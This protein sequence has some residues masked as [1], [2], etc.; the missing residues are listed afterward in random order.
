MDERP[1]NL[2]AMLAEAKDTSELM[3]DLAYAALF[4]ADD[5]MAEE[6]VDLEEQLSDLVHDMRTVSVLAVRSPR[7]AEQMSGV[8]HLISAIERMGN[9]AVDVAKIVT[10]DLGIPA[11]L[12]A[13]LAAAQ[14]VSHRVRVREGSALDGRSLDE[15]ELPVETGFRV[16][17]IR[18]A[19]EWIADPD[20]DE[21]LRPGDVLI[22]RGPAEGIPELRELAGAPQ[23]RTAVPQE[24]TALTDLDRAVDVLVD[25]KNVS[26]AAV[27]LAYSALLYK[28]AGLAAEVNSLEDRLDEMREHLEVWVMRAAAETVDPSELRGLLH[29]G[30]SAEE[31]GDAAQ[32]MVWLIEEGEEIHPVLQAALGDTDDVVIRM[33]VAA[34]STLDGT[35][36]RAGMQLGDDTG[37]FLL[38]IRRGGRYLYRPRPGTRIE[39]GDELLAR[40]PWEGRDDLAEQCG[41]RLTDDEDTGEIE[42]EPLVTSDH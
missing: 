14:E 22:A 21:V 9:A 24:H 4:F 39:P 10:H 33:P 31:I 15:L 1:R 23:W 29:L 35:V 5:D 19:K 42:L 38:A 30:A 41:Y 7:D 28:D 26:E 37:F 18:R 34:G 17:A 40:G 8:L 13:D 20:D 36:L 3:V 2:K 27:G 11:A 25:M 6:V 16:V 12:V 32:Q